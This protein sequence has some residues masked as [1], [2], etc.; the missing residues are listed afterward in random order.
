MMR[1]V[2]QESLLKETCSLNIK[3]SFWTAL[4]GSQ[5]I[6][7]IKYCAYKAYRLF[8]PVGTSKVIL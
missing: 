8:F 5:M 1:W 7:T 6:S 4:K 3:N 2:I